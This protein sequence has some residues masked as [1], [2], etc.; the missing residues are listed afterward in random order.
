M[1]LKILHVTAGIDPAFG[2]VSQAVQTMIKGLSNHDIINEV[3]CLDDPNAS[4]LKASF[5]IYALGPGRGPWCYS[6]KLLPWLN[7]YVHKYDVIIIHG[8]WLY[9]AYAT[10]MA[11]QKAKTNH[12]KEQ[13]K[14]RNFKMFI[15]PHGMLDPYFQKAAGRKL[16][17]IRNFIYWK[18]FENRLVNDADGLLF[19]SDEELRLAHQSFRPFVPKKEMVVGLGVDT[20]PLFVPSMTNAFLNIC[21][22][23][24][25][26][27][28]FLF[29]GRIHQKKGIDILINA[30]KQ[31]IRNKFYDAN[32]IPKL[33]I[34]GPGLES[35]YGKELKQSINEDEELSDSVFFPGML[36]GDAKWGAFY[37]SEVFV[38]PSHQ[39]N[40]G[41]AIVESLACG[42]PVLISNKINIWKDIEAKGAGMV[43][44]DSVQGTTGLF[45][46]WL[47]LSKKEKIEMEQQASELYKSNFA[48]EQVIRHLAEVL[49]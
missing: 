2:G 40:F 29:L 30:Y 6:R 16:K 45:E 28:Y 37:G 34:A 1:A 15:M 36:T 22:E 12:G 35:E 4:F 24:F 9:H 39:E 20:P 26:H 27:S 5:P 10:K 32:E 13:I 21:P 46:R 17:A 42:K 33:V 47:L 41:I 44:E 18:V 31:I 8:L 49:Y 7:R 19:T 25:G 23:V 11:I 38:L 3:V 43:A 48:T 14:S